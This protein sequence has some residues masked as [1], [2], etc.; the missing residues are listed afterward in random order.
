MKLKKLATAIAEAERFLKCAKAAQ[1]A[2]RIAVKPMPGY[3]AEAERYPVMGLHYTNRKENGALRRSSMDLSR[4]LS[5]LR[6]V[7]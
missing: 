2:H 6:K 3:E 4:A 7:E 5:D 1:E